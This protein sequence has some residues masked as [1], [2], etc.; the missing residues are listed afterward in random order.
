MQFKKPS[1]HVILFLLSLT[2]IFASCGGGRTVKQGELSGNITISGAFAL[3]PLA[4][5]WAEGFMKENPGVRIDISAGGAGKGMTD[6]LSGMVDLAML[7]REVAKVE[8]NQGA[9]SITVAKD[10]VVP[11]IST[12]NPYFK[13]IK[14]VGISKARFSALYI[15]GSIKFWG[16]LLG[17][18]SVEKINLY[19]RSEACG[20]AEMW[21]SF[22]GNH[23]EDL[24]G[25]GVFGDP[26]MAD[27]VKA[28]KYALG[29]NNLIFAYDLKTRKCYSG[30][31][32]VPI[33]LN[34]D[35]KIEPQEAFYSSIDSITA[36]IKD[37]RYPTPPA[38]NL[39][40]ISN[41]KPQNAIV[42]AFIKYILTKGQQQ[43]PSAGYIPLKSEQIN[44][45]LR[46]IEL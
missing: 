19:T 4:I 40:F 22:L 5:Q 3:Y 23:Q 11:M 30:I 39:Y 13:E 33:D 27:A 14:K 6:V 36:A 29:Y 46:K 37:G 43:I 20:A 34:G 25:I 41:G 32:V 17:N 26:G 45:M 35:G 7:S 24:R 1:H 15:S 10:A 2:I 21:A 44:E 31:S 18:Q 9:W 16:E 28:D 42:T 8:S 38:R 12:S